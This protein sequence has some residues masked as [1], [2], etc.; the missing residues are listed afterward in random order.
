MAT[1]ARVGVVAAVVLCVVALAALG[2]LATREEGG[3]YDRMRVTI[4]LGLHRSYVRIF[5]DG[6][7]V[8]GI[9]GP[10]LPQIGYEYP[11]GIRP[12]EVQ[13]AAA[14]LGEA[15]SCGCRDVER[16]VVKSFPA[17]TRTGYLE[18]VVHDREQEVVVEEVN[19]D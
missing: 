13:V 2:V 16:L 17:P 14:V 5:V 10:G 8:G 12:S 11:I 6:E 15:K 3:P 9:C 7:P 1:K 4:F 19:P 18:V